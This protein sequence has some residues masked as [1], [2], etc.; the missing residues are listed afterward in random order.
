MR[1]KLKLEVKVVLLHNYEC[2][3]FLENW[4][5]FLEVAVLCQVVKEIMLTMISYVRSWSTHVRLE[6]FL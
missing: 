2:A 4:K 5:S 6:Y 1:N 3:F